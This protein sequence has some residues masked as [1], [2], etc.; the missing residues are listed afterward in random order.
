MNRKT[1]K[2]ITAFMTLTMTILMTLATNVSSKEQMARLK[3]CIENEKIYQ[4]ISVGELNKIMQDSSAVSTMFNFDQIAVIG[5]IKSGSITKEGKY[6]VLTD[7]SG[8]C[9]VD[10]SVGKLKDKVNSYKDGDTLVVYGEPSVAG[11]SRGNYEVDAQII[12]LSPSKEAENAEYIY[13]G[14]TFFKGSEIGDLTNR[15]SVQFYIPNGWEEK[16]VCSPLIN[17]GVKGYQYSLNAIPPLDKN[18][19]E[20]PELFCI[21]YFINETYLKEP[22]ENASEW[23]N[24]NIE[25]EII[26]NIVPGLD[27]NFKIN[28]DDITLQNGEEADYSTLPYRP[29]DGRD[30]RLEFVFRP[31]SKGITC[32]LY[33]YFPADY[34]V[35]HTKDVAYVVQTMKV[36]P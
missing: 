9:N 25:K 10:S 32:M 34:A 22:L 12:E 33:L 5:K 31:D 1:W 29:K 13:P 3:N 11:L 18:S 4:L 6:F 28:I 15:N 19:M 36:S 14:G 17:N 21:F 30:Y 26:K 35:R 27:E 23:D 24:E 7:K 20:Y 16:R 8:E 2:R